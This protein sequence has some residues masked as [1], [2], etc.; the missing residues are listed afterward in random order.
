MSLYDWRKKISR[1]TRTEHIP[2]Y[3][4]NYVVAEFY[5]NRKRIELNL[6]NYTK[7]ILQDYMNRDYEHI[8]VDINFFDTAFCSHENVMHKDIDYIKKRFSFGNDNNMKRAVVGF[9]IA[10]TFVHS[11]VYKSYTEPNYDFY[12]EN[13]NFDKSLLSAVFNNFDMV[14]NFNQKLID[15]LINIYTPDQMVYFCITPSGKF[16]FLEQ[17]VQYFLKDTKRVHEISSSIVKTTRDTTKI[18]NLHLELL[19][20]C[21]TIYSPTLITSF[22]AENVLLN[23]IK[24]DIDLDVHE[25]TLF[26]VIDHY[27]D[28][29]GSLD[30]MFDIKSDKF[31]NA[32]PILDSIRE[33]HLSSNSGRF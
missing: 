32:M 14:I 25:R 17:D 2:S 8:Y 15:F 4:G 30:I 9:I 27:V 26:K 22:N 19:K 23:L 11:M 5:K 1:V 18:L 16:R 13:V 7:N 20:V 29:E 21:D 10:S 6:K 33:Y 31:E 28:K 3:D 12:K 24:L